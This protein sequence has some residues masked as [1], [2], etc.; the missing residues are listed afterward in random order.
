M[1]PNQQPPI[2]SAGT[3]PRSA[4]VSA[5][6]LVLAGSL[7][8]LA[9]CGRSA[10]IDALSDLSGDPDVAGVSITSPDTVVETVPSAIGETTTTTFVPPPQVFYTIQPGDTLSVIASRYEV[11]IEALAQANGITDVN[12]IRPGQ[13]LVIPVDPVAVEVAVEPAPEST[14][15]A[16]P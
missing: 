7:V 6:G 5:L 15:P 14:A 1:T 16:Q 8:G 9:G 12:T 13:E 10:P 4:T 2:S 3:G 11:T